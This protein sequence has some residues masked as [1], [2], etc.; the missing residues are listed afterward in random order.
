MARFAYRVND[1]PIKGAS[2]FTPLPPRNPI[3]SSWGLVRVRSS[4]GTTFYH[5]SSPT[6]QY[7]PPNSAS[8]LSQDSNCAPDLKSD[9]SYTTTAENMGPPVPTRIHNDL[10]VPATA[11]INSP[12]KAMI[13][14]KM[15][16]R[17]AMPWPR[18]FQRW[19]TSG[20]TSGGAV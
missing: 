7:L 6:R 4:V 3:A 18:A 8:L 13:G 12:R 19:P 16:T 10:P 5:T 20:G 2:A 15:G 11:W 17:V 9:N 1:L 14:R